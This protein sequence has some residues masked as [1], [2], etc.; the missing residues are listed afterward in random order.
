MNLLIRNI[1]AEDPVIMAASFIA[2]GWNKTI[3]Q[4]QQ[5]HSLHE[6][7]LRQVLVAFV[8]N[9]F[10]GYINIVWESE[11]LPFK[12]ASIPELQDF[13]VLPSYQ[14]RGIGTKIMEEAE[15]F[16]ASR[17]DKVGIGVG[18]TS[19]YGA[20]Q[21]LYVKRGYIPDGRGLT[22]NN[23][24]LSYGDKVTVDDDLVLHLVKQLR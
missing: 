19:D 12:D 24:E 18:M 16:I 10:C 15:S 11:Y 3:W 13:N 6:E 23:C 7:G 1:T 20:A 9:V 2:I 17:S 14:N 4:F 22:W 21:R 5:Y 8:E